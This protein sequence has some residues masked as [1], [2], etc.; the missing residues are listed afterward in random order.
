M[1]SINEYL[2]STIKN[3][4]YLSNGFPTRPNY[5]EILDFLKSQGFKLLNYNEKNSNLCD[6]LEYVI[7]H[8][9]ESN[10]PLVIITDEM[11]VGK[12][13]EDKRHTWIRFCNCGNISNDNP[14]FLLRLFKDDDSSLPLSYSKL[15]AGT[16][17]IN[18]VDSRNRNL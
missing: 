2:S 16:I 14:I 8:A 11:F 13:R 6:V 5:N 9:K 12:S 1:K 10:V 7:E 4:N 15:G 17:E 18:D 3:K